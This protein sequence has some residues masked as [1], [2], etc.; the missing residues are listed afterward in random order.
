MAFEL[1]RSPAFA[2]GGE[3]P[4]K[5]TCDG[6]DLS[7]LLRWIDPPGNTKGF[8]L[9]VDDPDALAGTWVHWVIY[10]IPAT[11]RE[12][13]EGVPGQDTVPGIGTQG[14]NDSGRIS[15][16]GPCPPRGPTHRYFFKLYAL[17]SELNL[18]P[19]KTKA[20]LLKAIGGHTLERVELMGRYRRK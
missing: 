4:I 17:D 9:I 2:P 20:E 7:P 18:S 15:Y 12:L 11:I 10:G 5:H 14:V 13:P 16:E 8:A 19:G 1:L 6:P 3:I